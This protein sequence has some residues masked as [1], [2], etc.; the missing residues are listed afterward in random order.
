MEKNLKIGYSV[1]K[2]VYRLKKKR[3]AGVDSHK[4]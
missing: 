1:L 3:K 4:K 2:N